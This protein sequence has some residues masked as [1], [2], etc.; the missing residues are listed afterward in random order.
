MPQ[1][2]KAGGRESLEP[3]EDGDH[4]WEHGS[5]NLKA[6]PELEG[7]A[8]QGE[9]RDRNQLGAEHDSQRWSDSEQNQDSGQVEGCWSEGWS[10]VRVYLQELPQRHSPVLL[11]QVREVP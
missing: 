10:Q 5:Q 1:N 4:L 2:G 7:P 6:D 11:R 8:L 9:Y 3:K